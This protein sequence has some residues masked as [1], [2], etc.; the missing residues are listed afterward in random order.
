MAT[1]QMTKPHLLLALRQHYPQMSLRRIGD[2]IRGATLEVVEPNEDWSAS[3]AFGIPLDGTLYVKSGEEQLFVR[4]GE[5]FGMNQ[6]TLKRSNSAVL[7][8]STIKT[9]RY[10]AFSHGHVS[11]LGFARV[12]ATST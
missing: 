3:M 10:L 7:L 9:V 12:H 2:M 8:R 5:V 1:Q 6:Y 11:L 4:S